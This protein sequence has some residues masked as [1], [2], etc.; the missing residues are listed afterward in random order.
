MKNFK[1][2]MVLDKELPDFLYLKQE[3]NVERIPY[4]YELQLL[5]IVKHG[6][7]NKIDKIFNDMDFSSIYFG[8]LSNNK[9]EQK[10]I[11]AISLIAILCR[12][13]IEAGVSET[14]AFDF[15]DDQMRNIF[16]INEFHDFDEYMVR[17]LYK[18]TY[19]VY[20]NNMK[21]YSNYTIATIRYINS[22][23]HNKFCIDDLALNINI[24]KEYLCRLF[25]KETG[26]SINQYLTHQKIELAKTYMLKNELSIKEI[27]YT[28]NFSSESY[29]IQVF[30]KMTGQ[31]PNKYKDNA[32]K[33]VNAI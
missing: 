15:S 1:E 8:K 14:I 29:F 26:Q 27:A 2:M 7:I 20:Q 16:R 25:K 10:K 30:K 12:A 6:D 5:D 24:S 22:H 4:A 28:L 9:E 13:I 11:I 17:L 21:N 32:K 3:Y 23:L 33:T 31:T 19:L 18:Y